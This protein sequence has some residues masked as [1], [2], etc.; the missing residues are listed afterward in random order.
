MY[1]ARLLPVWTPRAFQTRKTGT[2]TNTHTHTH[3]R[4]HVHTYT[5][6]R[7]HVHNF[8]DEENAR[9]DAPMG[10]IDAP[11]GGEEEEMEGV[12]GV[13]DPVMAAAMAAGALSLSCLLV[14]LSV[15]LLV[16]LAVCLSSGCL[17]LDL[18]PS[19]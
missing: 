14:Y 9:F 15:Y 11:F 1:S 19:G 18:L 12:R 10:L 2:N 16:S 13:G 4:T 7:I 6:I 8:L 5:H 3:T 17:S